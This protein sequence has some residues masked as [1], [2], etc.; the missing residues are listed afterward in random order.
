MPVAKADVAL[1]VD[2]AVPAACGRGGA[3]SRGRRPAGVDPAV[4]RLHAATRCR[5]GRKS[6]AFALRFRAPDRTLTDDE[7]AEARDGAVAA[8]VAATGAEL[9]G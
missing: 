1:V 5:A 7:V 4:R 2:E 3:A 8:A 9:R 6:L